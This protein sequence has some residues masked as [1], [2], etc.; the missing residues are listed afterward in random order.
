VLVGVDS[1]VWWEVKAVV[2]REDFVQA[3]L[4]GKAHLFPLW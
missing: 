1:I 3:Q 4:V 2:C